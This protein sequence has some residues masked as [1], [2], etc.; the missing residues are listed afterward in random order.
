MTEPGA[1]I[2]PQRLLRL[3]KRMIDIYSPSGKEEELVD[4]LQGYLKRHGLTAIRQ[5]VDGRRA[6]LIVNPARA[7]ASLALVGHLDTVSAYD[8][9]EYGFAQ[10]G[11]LIRGLG[12][13]DMK[14]ACAAMIEAFVCLAEQGLTGA[15]A[16]LALVVG[17]EES[18]DGAERLVEDFHFP[19]AL[20]GEPTDLRPCLSH[21]GYLEIQIVTKARRLHASLANKARNPIQD[22]L[23]LLLRLSDYVARRRPELVFNIRDLVSPQA[24]FV[25]PESCEAWLDIHL[26]PAAPLGDITLEIEDLLTQERR[27]SPALDARLRLA[28]VQAGYELPAKGPLAEALQ[29]VLAGRSLEWRPQAFPS[30]SDANQLW[31]AGVK[32][33]LLGC[34]R[35][36]K[37]HAPD[38]SVSFEQVRTAA[39]IYFQVAARMS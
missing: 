22:M 20:L 25:V 35:L 32:P 28:T 27:A 37:A 3:L 9:D 21:Y 14:G 29:A 26:P 24:G 6:N 5:E 33:I 15:P 16:A 34:G 36:D 11:D 30:H 39:E 1:A 10:E 23:K 12:A 4:Y 31:A 18:G 8:L 17:E 19:W 2:N 7:E 38:E 13:A